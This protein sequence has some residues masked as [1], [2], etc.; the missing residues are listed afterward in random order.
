MKIGV[1]YESIQ[2]HEVKLTQEVIDEVS[3]YSSDEQML[4]SGGLSTDMLDR[5]AFGFSDEDITSLKPEQLHIKWKEDYKNVIWEV[6]NSGLSKVAWAKRVDLSEPIDVAYEKDR[7]YIED[8]H[9]RYYAAKILKVP[10]NVQLEIKQNPVTKL[11]P[12]LGYDQLM[13]CIFQQVHKK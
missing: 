11:S 4:R 10:L 9:H 3:K 12:S 5:L 2:C 13:R 1:I 8:G 6:A 7:F